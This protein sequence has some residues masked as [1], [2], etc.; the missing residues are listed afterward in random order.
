MVQ[1]QKEKEQRRKSESE[2]KTALL[3][4]NKKL[5]TNQDSRT[6]LQDFINE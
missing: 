6:P 2:G 1:K 5:K 4:Y 3:S